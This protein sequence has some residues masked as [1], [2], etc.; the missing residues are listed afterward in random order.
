VLE[1]YYAAG[2]SL[3]IEERD[4]SLAE[5]SRVA[6]SSVGKGPTRTTPEIDALLSALRR[7]G[8]EPAM[9]SAQKSTFERLY[10]RPARLSG[11]LL[12]L[13]RPLSY[14]V[15]YD[16]AIQSGQPEIDKPLTTGF[17]SRLRQRFPEL[18]PSKG[19]GERVW[20]VALLRAREKFL[21]SLPEEVQQNS[22]YRVHVL[23]DLCDAEMWDL[24]TPFSI[25]IDRPSGRHDRYT[26]GATARPRLS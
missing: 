11:E 20:V 19:G 15:L 14:A 21:L 23:Q 9:Q 8:S 7:A 3:K 5:A 18:P 12:K 4:L 16:C 1:A 10:W 25:Q 2:A 22:V 13:R 17:V 24:E 26:I 6:L